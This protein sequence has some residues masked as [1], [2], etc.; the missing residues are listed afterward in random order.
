MTDMLRVGV[1]TPSAN[2]ILEPMTQRMLRSLSILVIHD[3]EE[4]RSVADHIIVM[5]KVKFVQQ[6]DAESFYNSPRTRVVGEFLGQINWFEGEF[7]EP[8]EVGCKNLRTDDRL[9]VLVSQDLPQSSSP[10]I[11]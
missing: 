3:Q 11:V 5:N 6:D 1:L 4:A 9:D 8:T 10:Q 2:T 7:G